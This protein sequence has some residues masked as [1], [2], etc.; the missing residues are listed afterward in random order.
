MV[1]VGGRTEEPRVFIPNS[2]FAARSRVLAEVQT[3]ESRRYSITL[4]GKLGQ[5]DD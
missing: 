3:V 2:S 1:G 4:A 5:P